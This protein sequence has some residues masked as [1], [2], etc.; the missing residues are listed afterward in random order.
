MATTQIR[1][2]TQIMAGTI[3]D[4]QIAAAAGIATSKLANGSS[5]FWKDGS[6]TAT[7]LWNLGGFKIT[8]MGDPTAASDAATKNYVDNLAS[9][10][11]QVKAPALYATTGNIT[12]SGLTTQ[13]NGDWPSALSGGARI[14]VINQTTPSQNGIYT[15]AAGAWARAGDFNSGTNIVAN[16]FFFIQQGTTLADTGWV[17]TTDGV[18]VPD[19]TPLVFVQFSSAGVT[20]PGT[21]LSKSGNTLNVVV[22]NG[23]TNSSNNLTVL[24][25]DSTLTVSASGVQLAALS[26]AYI[27]V[28]NGSSV[29]TG[30]ALSGDATI[31]NAGVLTVAATVAKYSGFVWSETPSGSVNGSNTSFVLAN[32]PQAGTVRVHQ[33]GLRLFAGAGN[34]YTISGGTI[35]FITAP[36]TGDTLLVDYVK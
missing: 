13:A 16:S 26:P 29:A 23:L 28:G 6:V 21:C 32:T 20:L 17:M 35:T 24:A 14:A 30:V 15:A 7:A 4:A 36:A 22:G 3:L 5:F 19:T 34:D 11:L 33:N 25:A 10:G 27:L 12:L 31:T 8:N 2:S 9:S 18:V 1:G